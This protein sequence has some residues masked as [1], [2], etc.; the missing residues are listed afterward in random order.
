MT[1]TAL[2][3][4]Q[5]ENALARPLPSHPRGPRGPVARALAALPRANYVDDFL[6]HKM[7]ADGVLPAPLTND[8]EFLRR[9]TLDLTG[10]IPT[11]DEVRAFLAD[12]RPDKRSKKIDALL[13]SDAFVDSFTL[14]W[15]NRFQVTS[16]YYNYIGLAGRTLFHALLRD[17]VKDDRSF[18]DLAPEPITAT[19]ASD[20]VGAVNFIVRGFQQGDPVQDT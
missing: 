3:T 10:R 13:S 5:A 9:V 17:F 1:R 2:R 15:G 7:A 16:R 8:T 12:T 19:G 18:R 14:Y 20:R 6:F 11:P 4:R